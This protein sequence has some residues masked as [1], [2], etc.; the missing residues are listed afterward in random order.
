V[1]G[2]RQPIGAR[3]VGFCAPETPVRSHRHDPDVPVLPPCTMLSCRVVLATVGAISD[4]HG[5]LSPVITASVAR[6]AASR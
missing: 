4:R 1:P 5:M 2:A 6:I 3:A